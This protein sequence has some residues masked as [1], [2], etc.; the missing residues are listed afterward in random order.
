MKNGLGASAVGRVSIALATAWPPFQSA[1]FIN[2]ATEGL[3]SLELKDRVRHIMAAMDTY[4]PQDFPTALHVVLEAGQN[5]PPGQPGDIHPFFAPWPLI[6]WIGERGV[7]HRDLTLSAL[8]QLTQIFSAEFAI[9]PLIIADQDKTLATLQ[10][11]LTD[12]NE[13]V[14]RLVSEGTR[15]RLPWGQNLKALQ[16]DPAPVLALLEELKDDP[17]LYVRKSVANNLNEICKDHPAAMLDVVERWVENASPDRLWIVRHACRTLI[18]KG[19][20]RALKLLG[21]TTTPKVECTLTVNPQELA[22]GGVVTIT[23][24]LKSRAAKTQ[25]LMVDYVV[26]HM[27][28]KGKTTPKV[29]KWKS[30]ELAPGESVEFVKRHSSVPRSVR[31]YYPGTHAVEL[32]VGG[33]SQARKEFKL[34]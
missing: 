27:R 11:W 3:E 19:D 1:K 16:A 18:K 4:L 10:T 2:D 29:F 23:V 9:R 34:I 21:F 31:R 26:H 25:N 15:P 30:L 12:P 32:L 20:P 28:S 8:R 5:I 13:H 22:I 6:D 17:A 33:K 24:Q 14:R 7:G